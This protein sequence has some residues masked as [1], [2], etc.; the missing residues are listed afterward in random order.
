M[1]EAGHLLIIPLLEH[2]RVILVL[3]Y[4]TDQVR[5]GESDPE[6]FKGMSIPHY[7]GKKTNQAI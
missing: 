5:G 4:L 2:W 6:T 7:L 3:K 1:S